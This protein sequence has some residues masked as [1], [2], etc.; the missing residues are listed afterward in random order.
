MSTK[1][2]IW[3]AGAAVVALITSLYQA[4]RGTAGEDAAIRDAIAK[5]AAAIEKGDDDTAKSEAKALAKKIE[6]IDVVMDL[7]KL[8][9]KDGTGGVG[10]GKKPGAIQPDGIDL[11][12]Q[13]IG[14]DAP[15][16]ATVN[17]EA[18]AL[19]K[20]AYQVAAIAEV[21]INKPPKDKAKLWI[22]WAKDLRKAAPEF[23][24]AAKSMSPAEIQKA[25]TSMT[26]SCTSCHNEFK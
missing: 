15:G 8:R 2:R 25:A 22:G 11:K 5:I 10:V 20:L 14:R 21:A 9:K 24:K 12:L 23:A 1:A 7:M 16:Q 3:L 4:G 19:E 17:K 26:R 6:E 18:A 13:K